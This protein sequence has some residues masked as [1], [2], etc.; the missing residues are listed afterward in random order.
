MEPTHVT[1]HCS[2]LGWGTLEGIRRHHTKP[3]AKR[4]RGWSDIGYHFVITNGRP[5][6]LQDGVD[7]SAAAAE[8]GKL[9][10]GRPLTRAGAGV[11]GH[12]RNN[13]QMC[14]IGRPGE[15]TTPQL[16]TA[17]Q[18]TAELCRQHGIAIDNVKGH[19]EYNPSKSCP[20]LD[21]HLVRAALRLMV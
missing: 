8:N 16:V 19:Y 4:G 9:W 11:R 18:A 21:M 12:N 14:L 6:L 3:R 10:A 13:I 5:G 7:R 17:F 20:G 15:F 2:A 1:W